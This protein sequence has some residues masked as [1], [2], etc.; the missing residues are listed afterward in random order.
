MQFSMDDFGTGY[1]SFLHLRKLVLYEL[2]IDL[3]FVQVVG[4]NR[5]AEV[6]IDG[7]ISIATGLGFILLPK[8]LKPKVKPNFLS[9]VDAILV[10]GF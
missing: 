1:G 2:K 5:S 3:E 8:G 4:K 9:V 6:I 7:F 10:K